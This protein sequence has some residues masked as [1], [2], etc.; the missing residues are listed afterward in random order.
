MTR[1]AASGL[2]TASCSI[3]RGEDPGPSARAEVK[4]ARYSAGVTPSAR[5]MLRWKVST[6]PKPALR[7][8]ARRL[9]SVVSSI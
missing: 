9:R 5:S 4:R 8:T 1:L 3:R 7:A 2:R 6:V